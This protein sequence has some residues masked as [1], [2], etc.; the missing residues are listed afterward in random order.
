MTLLFWSKMVE[1]DLD[2]KRS[3]TGWNLPE[4]GWILGQDLG[5]SCLGE[6][7]P[8]TGNKPGQCIGQGVP[9]LLR[10]SPGEPEEVTS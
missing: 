9:F 4:S 3:K 5:I 8:V 7:L 2:S 10:N 6:S 1:E